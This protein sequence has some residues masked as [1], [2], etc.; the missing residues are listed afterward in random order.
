M[1]AAFA[2]VSLAPLSG[3]LTGEDGGGGG[4]GG[5]ISF[6]QGFVYVRGEDIYVADKQDYTRPNS[7]TTSGGN[8]HPSLSRDGRSVVFVHTDTATGSQQIRTVATAGSG[9]P[10]TV[11]TSDDTQKNFRTPVFSPDG[12]KIV[13][14][15][16]KGT[17]TNSI[18]ALV[19]TDGS[20]F[21]ELTSG[22]LS[23]AA[24]V[25]YPDGSGVLAIA[26]SSTN[27][28]QLQKV[29]VTGGSTTTVASSLDSK[30]AYIA[31]RAVLSPDGTKVAFDG[32]LASNT[33]VARIFVMDLGTR[34]TNQ[35]TNYP[36]DA[37]AQDGF[38]TWVSNTQVGFTSNSGGADNVY[39]LPAS[40]VE[41]SG[42]LTVPSGTQ[43]WFGGGTGSTS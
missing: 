38:P 14:A 5:P 11:Y 13:F 6:V 18:L 43:P 4:G 21:T 33:S 26:G 27:Y 37:T 24:P 19:N 39:I 17:G 2:V 41:T 36:G 8:K 42:G 15:F 16:D 40:S 9:A 28:N 20:G 32:R 25:F 7:L 35:L 1:L 10:R 22:T 12:T 34:V 31:N 3:C 30:V 23:Y 29:S